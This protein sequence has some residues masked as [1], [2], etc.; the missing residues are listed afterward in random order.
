MYSVIRRYNIN[1]GTADKIIQRVNESFLPE[2]RNVPGFVGY[3]LVKADEG[4]IVSVSIFEERDGAEQSNRLAST[5]VRG[6]I[7]H[8]IKTTPVI[9]TGEILAHEMTAITG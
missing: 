1:P 2:L 5:W 7:Q 8:M 3:W 4:S 6:N 9:L